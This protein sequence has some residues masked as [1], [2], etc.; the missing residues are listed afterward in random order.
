[1]GTTLPPTRSDLDPQ[2]LLRLLYR[3]GATRTNPETVAEP[4][5]LPPDAWMRHAKAVL[6]DGLL[7]A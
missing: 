7:G 1:M 3:S 6:G 2:A 5:D 4:F